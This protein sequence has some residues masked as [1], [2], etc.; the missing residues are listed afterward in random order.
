VIAISTID[1]VIRPI[2]TTLFR[3]AA[4]SLSNFFM[5]DHLTS[6]VAM[7]NDEVGNDE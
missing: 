5:I 1:C 6:E 2:S 4:S 3:S 7:T